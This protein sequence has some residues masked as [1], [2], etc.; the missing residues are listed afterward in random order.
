LLL[1][2]RENL[3]LGEKIAELTVCWA[4]DERSARTATALKR[5]VEHI[6]RNI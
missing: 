6:A 5:C 2:R 1:E 3:R 4:A